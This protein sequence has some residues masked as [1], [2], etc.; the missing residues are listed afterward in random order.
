LTIVYWLF[1][2]C[3]NRWQTLRTSGIQDSR[4]IGGGYLLGWHVRSRFAEEE[5]RVLEIRV[6]EYKGD[7]VLRTL[8]LLR[9]GS[10]NTVPF[11]ESQLDDVIVM[12]GPFVTKPV[13][14]GEGWR[15]PNLMLQR[16]RDY[17]AKFPHG[18]SQGFDD[19]I[20]KIFSSLDEK[21]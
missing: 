9:A 18:S 15:S 14:R 17:R 7:A 21:H 1:R 2:D 11:L 3:G 19:R 6:Q 5:A 16:I 4:G 12:L 20:S 8:T 13:A 10:T